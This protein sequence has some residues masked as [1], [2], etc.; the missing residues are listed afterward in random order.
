MPGE[1]AV[2]PQEHVTPV[3]TTRVASPEIQETE[4]DTDAT[5]LQGAVSGE[6]QTLELACTPWAAAFESGD[7]AE[8]DEEVTARSTLERGLEWARRTFDK[9]ILPMTSVSFFT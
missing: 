2:A 8:D 1:P 3:G 6:A 4:E 5:L 9:L 7:D